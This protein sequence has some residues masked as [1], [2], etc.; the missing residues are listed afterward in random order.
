MLKCC[1]MLHVYSTE[2]IHYAN[3]SMQYEAISIAVKIAFSDF[4]SKRLDCWYML[5]L[6]SRTNVYPCKPQL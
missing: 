2:F 5:D 4:C 3:I 1:V 6:Y